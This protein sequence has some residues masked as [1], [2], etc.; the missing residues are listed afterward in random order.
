[1][2]VNHSE[3]SFPCYYHTSDSIHDPVLLTRLKLEE[4]MR[5]R[6]RP[7]FWCHFDIFDSQELRKFKINFIGL[8]QKSVTN[9]MEIA[10]TAIDRCVSFTK[11][12]RKGLLCLK[13]I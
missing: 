10:E 5:I 3:L 12:L 9:A 6:V 8:C 2:L 4:W 11:T 1:M 13:V 7:A